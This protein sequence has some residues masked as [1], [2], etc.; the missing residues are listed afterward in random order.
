MMERVVD[1]NAEVES[2]R[3]RGG[4]IATLKLFGAWRGTT[5][6]FATQPSQVYLRR[7]FDEPAP[8]NSDR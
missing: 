7:R 2:G 1:R 8:E 5:C 3:P 4:C 6:Q